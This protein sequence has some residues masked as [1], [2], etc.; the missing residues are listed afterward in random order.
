LDTDN[1]NS[2]GNE[3]THP[4][5]LQTGFNYMIQNNTIASYTGSGSNWSWSGQTPISVQK[6]GAQIEVKIDKSLV[7]TNTV[8]FGFVTRNASWAQIGFAPANSRG[9][10]TFSNSLNCDDACISI[11]ANFSDWSSVPTR[12]NSNG[13]T[14]KTTH[15]NDAFYIYVNGNL[16]PNNQFFLDTDNN[17]SG[18]NEYISNNWL[19]TGFNYMI[20]NNTIAS[21]TGSGSNWSWSGQTPISV[22]KAG[23]QIEVK[24]DKSIITANTVNFGF[25]TR[26]A[27]WAQIGF[28]PANSRGTHPLSDQFSCNAARVEDQPSSPAM[29]IYPNPTSDMINIDFQ[30]I[31]NEGILEIYDLTGKLLM[32]KDVISQAD[33]LALQVNHLTQGVYIIRLKLDNGTYATERFVKLSSN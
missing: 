30:N 32:T 24:I 7:T 21:Y 4:N 12:S 25:V 28:A 1:N 27:S 5:W 14:I 20:Q 11:D 15:D 23:T 16:G 9:T 33:N 6:A 17:N 26:N 3:Y 8:N 2:G 19:Q 29:N 13:F 22:Q 18:G 10:H 31:S